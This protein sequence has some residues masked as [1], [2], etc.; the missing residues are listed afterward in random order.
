MI[1]RRRSVGAPDAHLA[2][3][4]RIFALGAALALGGIWLDNSWL[5]GAAI[6]TLF[7]GVVLRVRASRLEADPT[8]RQEGDRV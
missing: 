3:K 5:V 7:A 6:V 1:P 8:E 4:V 2:A